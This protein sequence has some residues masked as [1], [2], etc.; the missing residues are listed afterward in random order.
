MNSHL[1]LTARLHDYE[2][3]KR[4]QEAQKANI[5]NAEPTNSNEED[6]EVDVLQLPGISDGAVEGH[7]DLNT[8]ERTREYDISIDTARYDC[9]GDCRS[10]TSGVSGMNTITNTSSA[11][12]NMMRWET[13]IEMEVGIEEMGDGDRSVE[14]RDEGVIEATATITDNTDLDLSTELAAKMREKEGR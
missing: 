9:E 6:K 10:T 2:Q 13:E 1:P 14:I 12:P 3:F 5:I 8:N 11:R 4:E 7:G